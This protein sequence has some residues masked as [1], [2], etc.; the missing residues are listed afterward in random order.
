MAGSKNILIEQ[1]SRGEY[2]VDAE[3]VAEAIVKRRL[4]HRMRL[5]VLEPGKALGQGAIRADE[6][7]GG[8]LPDLA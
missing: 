2:V 7:D 8:V 5:R 6:D 3:A 1:V 4:S